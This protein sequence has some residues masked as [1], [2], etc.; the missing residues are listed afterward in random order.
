MSNTKSKE[1]NSAYDE[2]ENVAEEYE[3]RWPDAEE[4][5][6]HPMHECNTQVVQA[7][8][9]LMRKAIERGSPVTEEE[10][11]EAQDLSPQSWLW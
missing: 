4:P 11:D 6:L 3:A 1:L 10:S 8:T 2:Y 5:C 9:A 7:L